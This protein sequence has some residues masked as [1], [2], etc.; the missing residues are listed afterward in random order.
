[1]ITNE[2]FAERAMRRLVLRRAQRN[3]T[4]KDGQRDPE[5]GEWSLATIPYTVQ[6]LE[7]I[8]SI[9]SDLL[10]LL[11]LFDL[12]TASHITGR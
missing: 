6:E 8:G 4:V 11:N 3:I 2:E 7:L 12:R 5:T 9:E 10:A 1:M